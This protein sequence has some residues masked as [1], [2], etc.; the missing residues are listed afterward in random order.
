[1]CTA[2]CLISTTCSKGFAHLAGVG[3][4]E[5]HAESH[6]VLVTQVSLLLSSNR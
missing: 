3:V 1:M 5:G 6:L 4:S 2:L